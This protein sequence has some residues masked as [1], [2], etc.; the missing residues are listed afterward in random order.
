MII[1]TGANRGLGKAIAER[2]NYNGERVIGLVRSTGDLD[3]DTFKC[4]VSNY[5]S[6]KNAARVIKAMKTPIKAL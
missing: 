3:I 4:D 5:Q 6:V 1:I 2:L